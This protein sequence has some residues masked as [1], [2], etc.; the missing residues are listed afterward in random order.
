MKHRYKGGL[1]ATHNNTMWA[2]KTMVTGHL[3]SLK[4]TPL[5][6]YNGT[7]WGVDSGTLAEPYGPQFRDYTETNPLNWRP[8]FVVLTFQSGQLLDPEL[9]RVRSEGEVVFR[10]KVI[11]V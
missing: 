9:V 6:D 11:E 3:H 2:G 7:R 5:T 1:H 8:G 10:G 4:V